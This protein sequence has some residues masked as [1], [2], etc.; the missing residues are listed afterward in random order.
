MQGL[1]GILNLSFIIAPFSS[2]IRVMIAHLTGTILHKS[3]SYLVLEV[4]SVGY[5]IFATG[6]TLEKIKEDTSLTLWVHQA[7]RETASDLYGFITRD[8]LEFFE[9]LISISGIGPKTA[10][11]ILNVANIETL[12]QAVRSGNSAHLT[13]ISGL[14]KKNAEKIVLELS[15][16]IGIGNENSL[17]IQDEGDAIEA[18]TSL[19][20]SQKEARDA[21]REVPDEIV[22]TSERVKKALKH[23]GK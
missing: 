5:K 3:E 18:L 22:G 14:G 16:K 20:Y 23:L 8:E 4:N 13:K 9:L 21:L 12:K 19:G 10:L 15:G 6:N 17:N 7:I 11:G 2:I 1:L